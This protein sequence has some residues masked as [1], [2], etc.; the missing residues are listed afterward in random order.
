VRPQTAWLTSAW[1]SALVVVFSFLPASRASV[2]QEKA[3]EPAKRQILAIGGG[4]LGKGEGDGPPLLMQYFLGLT[5]KKKPR[6]C[7]MPSASGDAVAEITRWNQVMKKLECEPRVQKVYIASPKVKSFEDELLKADAIYIGNG[8]ALNMLAM[9]RAQGIDKIIR[10]AYDRGTVLGGEGAGAICWFEQG[11]TDSRPG[12][13]TPMEC[14]GFLKGSNCPDF[15]IDKN[16]QPLFDDWISKGEIKD[17]LAV[18]HGVG[19]HFVDEK[20][21]KV[22]SANPTAQAF[23]VTR[24]GNKSVAAALKPELLAK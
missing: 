7:F 2:Q 5:G 8:N 11:L 12:K 6:V 22:V 16:R 10:Q 19:L 21:H 4:G 24:E 15:D 23:R 17:G 20:L 1:V 14:L 13:L 9:W 18:D 3:Q